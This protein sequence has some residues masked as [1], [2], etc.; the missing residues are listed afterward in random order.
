MAFDEVRRRSPVPLIS[1]VEATCDAALDLNLTRVG[2]L[3]TRYTMQAQFYPKVFSARGI[4]VVAPDPEDL[5]YVHERSMGELVKGIKRPETREG[6]L[7]IARRLR[8]EEQ[9][10]EIILGGTKLPLILWDAPNPSIPFLDTTMI[11]VKSIVAA[12]LS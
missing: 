7:A 3:G 9:V 11:H 8:D 4:E 1:I 12:M 5:R 10:G 2:V 6:L